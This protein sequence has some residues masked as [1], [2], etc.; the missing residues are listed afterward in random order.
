MLP[1]LVGAVLALHA[2]RHRLVGLLLG[3]AV[4]MKL[5]PALALAALARGK[6]WRVLGC[7]AL[8]VVGLYG[9]YGYEAGLDVLGFLPDYVRT[10]EDHNVG[11]RRLLES[12]LSPV[13]ERPRTPAFLLCLAVLGFATVW[14]R[15]RGGP[16][17]H[18]LGALVGVY[19]LTL[20][21]AFHPWYALWWLPWICFRPRASALWLSATLPLSYLKYASPDGVMPTWVPLIEFIPAGLFFL[22]EERPWRR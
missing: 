2:S 7:C 6:P 14:I 20:P 21:T 15:R 1:L 9:L 22:A 3:Q 18:Q 4:A 5:Y 19:L 13:F 16:V 12:A 8:V 10:A 17:V 11:L